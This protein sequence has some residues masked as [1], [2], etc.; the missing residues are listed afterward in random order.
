MKVYNKKIDIIRSGRKT[1][2]LEITRA[3]KVLARAPYLMPDKDIQRFIK[4]KSPWIESHMEIMKKKIETD[5][6]QKENISVFTEEE[7]HQ[8]A[9]KA[10]KV[11]PARVAY[12]APIVGTR[13]SRITI[14]N[15]VSRWGSCSS[16]GS[17]SFNCLLMLTPPRCN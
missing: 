13:F 14:R 3:L 5:A 6:E 7:I 11:I 4:E 1:L 15:Q 10:L 2:A 8:L 17:L 9:D 16:K 12:Y